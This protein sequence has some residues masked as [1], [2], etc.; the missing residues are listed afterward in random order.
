M[1]DDTGSHSIVRARTPLHVPESMQ[2][3]SFTLDIGSEIDLCDAIV[4]SAAIGNFTQVKCIR[5]FLIEIIKESSSSPTACNMHRVRSLQRIKNGA[6]S[7]SPDSQDSGGIHEMIMDAV[8]KAMEKQQKDIDDRWSRT[9]VA[10]GSTAS[11]IVVGIIVGL[12]QYFSS[13]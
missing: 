11:S 5:P 3:E 4:N 6:A 2:P 1:D 13:K 9:Q 12:S 7:S 10:I 8:Q